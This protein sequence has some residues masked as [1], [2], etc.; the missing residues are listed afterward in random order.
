MRLADIALRAVDS[1]PPQVI[2]RTPTDRYLAPRRRAERRS[3]IERK[4]LTI[5]GDRSTRRA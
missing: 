2:D 3:R 1:D 4:P 5:D